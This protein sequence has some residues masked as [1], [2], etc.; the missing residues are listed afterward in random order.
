MASC[1]AIGI[2]Q[3][4][5]YK[6]RADGIKSFIDAF[7][8][9]KAEI[10]FKNS[11]II[12]ICKMIEKQCSGAAKD[13]FCLIIAEESIP[14]S[15]RLALGLDR[16]QLKDP[17]KAEILSTLSVLGRYDGANQTEMIDKS[18]AHLEQLYSG[19]KDD[20]TKSGKLSSAFG[21]TAGIVIAILLL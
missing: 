18:V 20:I 3:S 2:L 4:R 8:V 14:D 21:I 15:D 13:Y 1:S 16:Y 6:Q 7:S 5:S 12:E 17:E 11:T 19:A 10:V 9:A